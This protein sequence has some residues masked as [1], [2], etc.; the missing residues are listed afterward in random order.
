MYIHGLVQHGKNIAWNLNKPVTSRRVSCVGPVP[1]GTESAGISRWKEVSSS[2]LV[3]HVGRLK[4]VIVGF[5]RTG[6]W[7]R[8]LGRE[9]RKSLAFLR[10]SAE[11][12]FQTTASVDSRTWLGKDLKAYCENLMDEINLLHN[13]LGVSPVVEITLVEYLIMGRVFLIEGILC[14]MKRSEC[15][16]V[17]VDG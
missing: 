4:T 14:W 17:L 1:K 12:A 16:I 8:I 7:R 3:T 5:N 11:S 15:E 10:E 9:E 13:S 6:S 2:S